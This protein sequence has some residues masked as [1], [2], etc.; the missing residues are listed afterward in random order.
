[1]NQAQATDILFECRRAGIYVSE[2]EMIDKLLVARRDG[3]FSPDRLL[4]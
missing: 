3:A 1:M 4:F 2:M